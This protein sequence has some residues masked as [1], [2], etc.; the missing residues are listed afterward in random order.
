MG[1]EIVFKIAAIGILTSVVNQV[2]K[3][4]G[5]DEIATIATLSGVVISLLLVLSLIGN[6]FD[7]IKTMFGF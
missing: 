2:F 5:K 7:T 6:L 1:V 4:I 3:Q